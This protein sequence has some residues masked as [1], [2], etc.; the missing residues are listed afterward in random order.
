MFKSKNNFLLIYLGKNQLTPNFCSPCAVSIHKIRQFPWNLFTFLIKSNKFC[1]P[2]LKSSKPVQY[3][4]NVPQ[5]V[6]L[7]RS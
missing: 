5:I 1:T 2:L 4:L 7:G 6:K 3:P